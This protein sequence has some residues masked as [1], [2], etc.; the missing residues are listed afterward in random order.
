M[1]KFNCGSLLLLVL[2]ASVVPAQPSTL[3][4][5]VT[6]DCSKGESL[7]LEGL[8]LANLSSIDVSWSNSLTF[9]GGNGVDLFCDSGSM[10]TGSW[11][12]AGV[13]TSQCANVLGSEPALP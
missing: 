2:P 4:I 7:N 13:P 3:S 1:R 6:V 11:F 8:V 10:I 12:L 5:P 9:I